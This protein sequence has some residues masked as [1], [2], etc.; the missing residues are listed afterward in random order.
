MRRFIVLATLAA[1]LPALA[2]SFDAANKYLQERSYSRACEAFTAFVK[3]NPADPLAREASAKKAA[4][5]VR[6]GK[7]SYEELRKL[8]T[9]GEK[10]FARAVAMHTLLERGE[11]TFDATA[12]LL[13]QAMG[14]AG[15][16]GTEAR[17]MLE[18]ALVRE[19]DNNSW[20]LQRI[21][22]LTELGLSLDSNAE[23]TAAYRFRR[24]RARMS[25]SQKLK[26][27]EAELRFL[28]DGKTEVADD[29][30]YMLAERREN[31]AKYVEALELFEEIVKRFSPT[32]S[33]MRSNAESRAANIRRP[34]VS[35]GVSNNELPGVRPQ[36]SVNFRNVK[37]AKWTLKRADP[38]ALPA[39]SWPAD[40]Q[41]FTGPVVKSWSTTFTAPS[42][43]A[44]GNT[45]FELEASEPGLYVIEVAADGERSQAWA[46]ISQHVVVAKTDRT[47][48]VV[49][50]FDVETGEAQPDTDV[51]LYLYRSGGHQ[52]LTG[53]TNA[54]GI[55]TFKTENT[56]D[57]MVVWTKKG[58]NIAWSSAG[59]SYW[60]NYNREHLAYVMTDRPLYK[61]G[62]T[63]GLKLFLRSREGGPSTPIS[64]MKAYVRVTDPTGKQLV[65]ETVTTNAF[66]TASFTLAL[67][68]KI[69][70]GA[71]NITVET[72]GQYFTQTSMQFRVEEYKPPEYIVSV[73]ALGN[74]KPG[75]KVK[76]KVKAAYY[77]GGAVTNANGRALVTVKGWQHQ[78]GPWPDDPVQDAQQGYG[79]DDEE[80]GYRYK[81]GRGYNYYGQFAQHT[82]QFK[83]GSDGT[84]EVEAPAFEGGGQ[85]LEYA[86]QVFV[87]DSSRREIQGGG[88]IKLS[89]QPFF[90]DLKTDHFL[91]RPGERVA[92]RLRAEDANGRPADPD[93]VLRLMRL[94]ATGSSRITETRTR[95]SKGLGRAVLDAD[96][97]G[98]VRIEVLDGAAA[99]EVVIASTDLWL[100]SDAKPIVPGPG[101]NLFV[102]RAPLKVGDNLR[103]LV[104]G[105]RAG[106]HVLLTLESDVI[107]AVQMVELKGRARFVEFKLPA[108][109]SPNGWLHAYR[110][111]DVQLQQRQLPFRVK[112]SEVEIGV[113]VDFGKASAEPGSA[114]TA[115]VK[116]KGATAGLALET[117]LTVVDESLFAIAPERKDF[118][119][120][121][122]RTNRQQRVTTYSSYNQRY[123]RAR[124]VVVAKTPVQ[125]NDKSPDAPRKSLARDEEQRKD[126]PSPVE[127]APRGAAAP[128]MD[129]AVAGLSSRSAEKSKKEASS[130]SEAKQEKPQSGADAEEPIKVRSDF[131]T[132]AGWYAAIAS[133]SGAPLS[134]NLKLKDSL[135]SWK[136]VA[137]VVS[138][139][140]NLGQGSTQIRTAKALMVRLQAP[141]F[142]VEGDEVVL[143]AV[144]E[145]H[146]AKATDVEVIISAPGFK[147]LTPGK[148]TVRVEPEQ[149]L[150]VDAKFKVVDLGERLIRATVKGGGTSDGMEWKLPAFVHGSAQRQFFA[151]RVK[152][153]QSFEF[154]LPEKRKASLT[155]IEVSLSPT[156]LAVM[157]D[158]LPYLAEYPYG[159]VEQTLSRFV[160]ATIARRAVKDLNLPSTRVPANLDDM[161]QKGLERLYDFQ[162][163]DGG[164]GWWQSD[165]TNLWMTSYVVSSLSLAKSAGL[166]VRAEVIARGREYLKGHLG[167]GLNS[168]ETHAYMVYALASTGG[169][170]K[171]SIDTVYSR[172]TSLTPRAR[173]QL[174]LS[175]LH[176][177]DPRARVAVENLDD[178]VKAA[179]SRPDA[180]VGE[181]NDIW[182]TSAAIEATAFTLMAYAR[183]DLKSPLIAPLTDFL[184]LRRNGGRW[185]NTRDTAFAVYALADLARREGAADKTGVF[186]VMVNGKEV[187][188]VPYTKGGLDLT[189]PVTLGDALFKSGK[190]TI[191]VKHD[192]AGTGYF[193]AIADVFNMND[194]IKGIGGDVKVKRTYTVLGKPST[195][196]AST[197]S[198]EYG[199]PVESGVR[200][201]VDVELTA[202]KAVEFVMVED[203]KPAGFEAVMLQSG[204]AVC[205]YACAH[206]EL[207]TDRVAMFITQIPV[208]VTK[209]SYELR[210]EVPGRFAALPARVEAMYAPE[211]TATADEM[212]FEVRD[213][214]DGV[215]AR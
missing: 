212:R 162:H 90:V 128:E 190:N 39:G 34:N 183:Y 138:E 132:S 127:A 101:F 195:D 23:L 107:A 146:L 50:T 86:V 48:V 30:L 100:T 40:P 91:Y 28:G 22:K 177:K 69:T 65:R 56:N 197:T 208:G 147:E 116:T 163:G 184:V 67:D 80:G 181:A 170:P 25:N 126:G 186:V 35:V 12:P 214:P 73:E 41:N 81:R 63:V 120:F 213:A 57:S 47:Q 202:N 159:C 168:P 165:T 93:V 99:S 179:Q 115:M 76:F 55:A 203:L 185:R 52:K 109:V 10:D 145:S 33:N 75:D 49:A 136:A 70:L 61:P 92:V 169:V 173:A 68:K 187:K 139:G 166:D 88:S 123:H 135:T 172:R 4:A 149:V 110:F 182:S 85:A 207:R 78:F 97:V 2:Q 106:G 124:P 94:T 77:S 114:V 19:M 175:L 21:E 74:P 108:D 130:E 62:E 117:A 160:P 210:A 200:V 8:G 211:I 201:R 51:A 205:N 44:P 131:S 174:A 112:G 140:P 6:A 102:D 103:V 150:R 151:G 42:K 194:F 26:E 84:A 198:A 13:K 111:E 188:R 129:D 38:L 176:L 82:L 32:T 180:A 193:G 104:A 189:A 134:Q 83:T 53:K 14:E 89:P 37:N 3:A 66:G 143:S 64:G 98:Q 11:Q 164:W 113:E 46:L 72:D 178:V 1:S 125:Q 43:Y 18:G 24:A 9:E 87:T 7:G 71:C 16:R 196:R 118:L 121:F 215:V 157:F 17:A 31:E 105:N 152:D 29:A 122:G 58:S 133:K 79:Y 171:A 45:S 155:K 156:L 27:A 137:T 192:G 158:A 20:N 154:E 153:T 191:T 142:F 209:L 167:E 60:Q 206:A 204:P 5:C 36:V 54:S 161:T 95:L 141:R 96:A 59:G 199:M 148:K 15:R 144:V 119:S